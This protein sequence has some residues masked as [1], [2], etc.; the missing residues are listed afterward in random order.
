MTKDFGFLCFLMKMLPK[1]ESGFVQTIRI[2]YSAG[3]VSAGASVVASVV[4]SV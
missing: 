2:N 4:V 3:V 1:K